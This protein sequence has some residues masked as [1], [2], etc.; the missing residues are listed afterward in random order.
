MIVK[1]SRYAI[2]AWALYKA[3]EKRRN[4]ASSLYTMGSQ[5]G[6]CLHQPFGCVIADCSYFFE[7]L[8]SWA[9]APLPVPVESDPYTGTLSEHGDE[10][11]LA[12]LR[13]AN[14]VIYFD[15]PNYSP[16]VGS[17][18]AVVVGLGDDPLT[19]SFGQQSEP[20]LVRVSEDGRPHRFYAYNTMTRGKIHYPPGFKKAHDA[21]H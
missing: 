9:G 5:R 10:V 4:P 16:T 15:G 2:R 13:V 14:A 6:A 11:T 20:A 17:H 19:V 12:T 7:D 18:V 8:Y 21:R 3:D 1:E